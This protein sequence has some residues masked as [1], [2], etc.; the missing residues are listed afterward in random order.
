MAITRLEPYWIGAVQDQ[1][2]FYTAE[3]ALLICYLTPAGKSVALL[4][5]NSSDDTYSVFRSGLKG[6]ILLCSR[7]DSGSQDVP[8]RCFEAVSRSPHS[9]ISAVMAAARKQLSE[10]SSKLRAFE[11]QTGRNA[12]TGPEESF[13]DN[14]SFCTWNALGQDL[15]ATKLLNGLDQL[16]SAGI[17]I[18]T[19]LIDDN[20]QDP[21]S[22][23]S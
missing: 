18:S 20:W 14:F 11:K 21:R 12:T 13:F 4:A 16:S 19:L 9:A 5:L 2:Q 8:F 17:N 3:D 15:T 1:S 22:Y 7:S 10:K 6:E 23:L